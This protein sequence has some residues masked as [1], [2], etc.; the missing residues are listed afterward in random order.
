MAATASRLPQLP[1]AALTKPCTN[2][3]KGQNPGP[4]AGGGTAAAFPGPVRQYRGLERSRRAAGQRRPGRAGLSG[5]G[6][7]PADL[8]AVPSEE[9]VD[10][11]GPVQEGDLVCRQ[12]HVRRGLDDG[13]PLMVLLC[14]IEGG[15]DPR[16]ILLVYS[17]TPPAEGK[18]SGAVWVL[19]L[20]C[21][22]IAWISALPFDRCSLTHA[23]CTARSAYRSLG[24]VVEG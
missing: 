11:E 10:G 17:S 3:E 13:V 23:M 22:W 4:P 2:D 15:T 24:T 21:L 14:G 6:V 5:H 16:W 18:R 9:R 19:T 20:R 1:L 12:R 8:H 7:R